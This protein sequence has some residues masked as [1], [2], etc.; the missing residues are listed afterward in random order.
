M[1]QCDCI[2]GDQVQ[3]SLWEKRAVSRCVLPLP[4]CFFSSSGHALTPYGQ[5][6]LALA[7]SAWPKSLPNVRFR[8]L[9]TRRMW[10]APRLD[11]R[12]AGGSMHVHGTVTVPTRTRAQRFCLEVEVKRKQP[13]PRDQKTWAGTSALPSSLG[14]HGSL[15]D[16]AGALTPLLPGHSLSQAPL[17]QRVVMWQGSGQWDVSRRQPGLLG[18]LLLYLIKG[19]DM[20]IPAL[21]PTPS[22]C[23]E[24]KLDS[25]LQTIKH[26]DWGEPGRTAWIPDLS[27]YS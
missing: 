1:P 11:C 25:Q 10:K 12:R 13:W 17:Q 7:R 16:S 22:S 20:A 24:W 5:G 27:A 8:M 6:A 23:L 4:P 14:R 9:C 18:K 19:R 26:Q 21:F 2:V 3:G 15:A